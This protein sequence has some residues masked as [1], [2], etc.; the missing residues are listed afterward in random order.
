M[1]WTDHGGPL[2][3]RSPD[4][5]LK[6][7][8]A[9]AGARLRRRERLSLATGTVIALA[10]V[11]VLVGRGG[12][13]TTSL[14]VTGTGPA[15]VTV[16]TTALGLF[17]TSSAPKPTTTSPPTTF[18]VPATT[19]VL[20]SNLPTTSAPPSSL[21][22][23]PP[24]TAPPTT[25]T[26]P[27]PAVA[28]CTAAEVAV[29]ATPDK[30]TYSAGEVVKVAVAATNRSGH[31][32]TPVDPGIAVQDSTGKSVGGAGVVDIFTMGAPGQPPPVWHAG[33]TLSTSLTWPQTC[34]PTGCPPGQYTVTAKFG[35]YV[36]PPAIFTIG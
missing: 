10:A 4:D 22:T 6:V 2:P 29:T 16:P 19:T 25:T 27:P 11:V 18:A 30:A 33:Q 13:H 17:D 7:V 14:Q 28:A 5:L 32:C 20:P 15:S 35:P 8:Q 36:S 3:D 34:S 23:V 21:A 9:K 26:T 12:H 1:R 24:T 31:D